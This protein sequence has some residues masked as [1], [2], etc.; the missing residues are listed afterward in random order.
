LFRAVDRVK[1]VVVPDVPTY[2]NRRFGC[3]HRFVDRRIS[4]TK[5]VSPQHFPR[6]ELGIAKQNPPELDVV[7]V[8]RTLSRPRGTNEFLQFEEALPCA[9]GIDT[10]RL[11]F[12][13]AEFAEACD[14]SRVNGRNVMGGS[15]AVA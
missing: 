12:C 7:A 5:T 4:L 15:Q 8:H 1:G 6:R 10:S 14:L 11:C 3:L 13:L 2:R 9:I